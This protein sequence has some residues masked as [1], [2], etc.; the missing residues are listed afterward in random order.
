M[1]HVFP[2]LNILLG[3]CS[4]TQLSV[5]TR[6]IEMTRLVAFIVAMMLTATA[7]SEPPKSVQER[8]RPNHQ[9][10]DD[11]QC[12]HRAEMQKKD[13]DHRGPRGPQKPSQKT[14]A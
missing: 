4:N 14:D 10:I 8:E 6:R 2:E 11:A 12:P 13:A 3:V 5:K 1:I 7:Y 9:R